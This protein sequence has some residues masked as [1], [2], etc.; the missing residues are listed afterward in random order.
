MT[1]GTLIIANI[2]KENLY[3]SNNPEIIFFK[4]IYNRHTNYSIEQSPQYFKSIPDFGKRCTVDIGKN[5]DLISMIHIFINLPNIITENKQLFKWVDKIGLAIINFIEIEIGGVIIDRHYSDWLNIWGELTINQGLKNSYNK[6]IGNIDKLTNYSSTKQ[7]YKLYI[8]L[9]FWFCLDKG[10]SLPIISLKHNNVKLHVQFNEFK[11][12]YLIE[13]MYYIKILNNFCLIEKDEY[14]YQ[15]NILIGQYKYFDAQTQYLYYNIVKDN[16]IIPTEHYDNNLAIISEKTKINIYIE[17]NNISIKAYNNIDHINPLL[18]NSYIL[19]D[20]VY[21]DI[22]ERNKFLNNKIEDIIPIIQTIPEKII[23]SVN[24][25]YNLYLKYPI[26]LLVW[27]TLL[28]NNKFN[29]NRFNYTA[30]PFN[31]NNLLQKVLL[32]CN[33][34][35]MTEIDDI[36]YY[37][38][39]PNYQYDFY[40]NN[41]G[42]YNYSFALKPKDTDLTGSINFSNINNVYLKLTCNSI[43][44]Y[45]NPVS[46][47]AYAIQYRKIIIDKG[48]LI[49]E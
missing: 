26:K 14:L 1:I 11:Y 44:N 12:C 16:F 9:Y 28:E 34:V 36:E 29:N 24:S 38:Y 3:I 37:N 30:Q 33:S 8:P 17:P 42:I 31:N 35:N 39:I 49:L 27:R 18:I 5:A 45:Q 23:N 21:L 2:G 7:S 15:N 10:L 43:I 22:D 40:N 25:I 47:Q 13:P 4:K 6:M 41:D 19:V 48:I 32:N 20:Y 46:I